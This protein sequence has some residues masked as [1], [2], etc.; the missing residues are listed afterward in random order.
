MATASLKTLLLL[1]KKMINL[2]LKNCRGQFRDGEHDNKWEIVS[3]EGN[4]LGLF[5]AKLK[6]FEVMGVIHFA[7][8]F[9]N[10][11]FEQGKEFGRQA[12]MAAGKIHL[13]TQSEIIRELREENERLSNTLEKHIIGN[14]E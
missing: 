4:S 1:S 3:Q 9:E 14:T 13:D 7:R 5:P 11:A 8:D 10:K 6:D 2:P 12:A